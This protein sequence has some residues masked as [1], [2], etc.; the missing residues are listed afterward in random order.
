MGNVLP[1]HSK[2]VPAL[3]RVLN[4]TEHDSLSHLC[5]KLR[6]CDVLKFVADLTYEDVE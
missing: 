2:L 6:E 5:R 3:L 4:A 1:N